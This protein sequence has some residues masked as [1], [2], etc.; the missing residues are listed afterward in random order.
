MIF[1]KLF[2]FKKSLQLLDIEDFHGLFNPKFN[3]N[4]TKD[5][6]KNIFNK[7]FKKIDISTEL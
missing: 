2:D 4:F 1:I 7:T 5:D 6:I 3:T